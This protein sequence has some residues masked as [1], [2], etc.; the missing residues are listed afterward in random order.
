LPR[1]GGGAAM[2]LAVAGIGFMGIRGWEI[3]CQGDRLFGITQQ[4]QNFLEMTEATI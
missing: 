1:F 2:P 3:F 4:T